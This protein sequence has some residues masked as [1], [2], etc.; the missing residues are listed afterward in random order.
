[1]ARTPSRRAIGVAVL[2]L[3]GALLPAV[4]GLQLVLHHA[5]G[6]EVWLEGP[7]QVRV[8]GQDP[9]LLELAMLP[10]V[11]VYAGA[12]LQGVA[13]LHQP[14][15]PWEATGFTGGLW[16]RLEPGLL[17]GPTGVR[18]DGWSAAYTIGDEAG[19]PTRP[20]VPCRGRVEVLESSQRETER[21]R[22]LASQASLSL[23]LNLMCTS[24]GPD[25]RWATGDDLTWLLD[26]DLDLRRGRRPGAATAL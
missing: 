10:D 2:A 21:L 25:N 22:P 11:Q 13:R 18:E 17:T 6:T 12:E 9:L 20:P 26:G 3:V 5:L 14:I 7:V 19:T 1:V 8:A 16:L 4:Y 23:G 24:P 15:Y